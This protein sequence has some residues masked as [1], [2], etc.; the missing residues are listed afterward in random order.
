MG[1]HILSRLDVK[2]LAD[3]RQRLRM[4]A[5]LFYGL[6]DTNLIGRMSHWQRP[7]PAGW[8][9]STGSGS[10]WA[11]IQDGQAAHRNLLSRTIPPASLA[12]ALTVATAKGTATQVGTDH[13]ASVDITAADG[14]DDAIQNRRK[15]EAVLLFNRGPATLRKLAQLA[16]LADATQ[17]RTL[18]RALNDVYDREGSG[19]RIEE[20]AG[21]YQIFT[22]P[23]LAPWLRRLGSVPGNVR[24]SSPAMETLA[25]VAYR[26]PVLRAD[27]EAIRGVACGEIIRQLMQKDLVKIC[28]RSEELGRPY[29]Y[30]TTKQFLETFGLKDIDTLPQVMGAGFQAESEDTYDKSGGPNQVQPESGPIDATN[31]SDVPLSA[32][33]SID[34]VTLKESDVSTACVLD[35]LCDPTA[36]DALDLTLIAQSDAL[37]S[38]IVSPRAADDDDDDYFDD[39]D[40]E[41]D[42][43]EEEDWDDEEEDDLADDEEE[44]L[45][46]EEDEWEEVG[47]E[48]EE[49]E[50]LEEETTEEEVEETEE[51]EDEEEDWEEDD[52][53]EWDDDD[54]EEEDEDD[55]DWD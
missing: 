32:T 16:D 5:V 24:L 3:Y 4:A 7:I 19:L 18:I 13:A 48:D 47:D 27:V 33:S 29:L 45:D 1:V 40:D 37:S 26:Q 49:E 11:G 22:R 23:V 31:L 55:E 17:A 46:E 20:I 30:G 34:A 6:K 50:D 42:D 12:A 38:T 15:L 8:A 35:E 44:D 9:R 28:G 51:E 21:G 41:D 2:R 10:G 52:D 39:D 53:E 43:D 25:I 54:D 36:F 14:R